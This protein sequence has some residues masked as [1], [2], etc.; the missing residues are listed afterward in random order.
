VPQCSLCQHDHPDDA[1]F[2]SRCGGFLRTAHGGP[3]AGE[4]RYLTLIF[5][6]LVD[7]TSLA[8]A[9]GPENYS[10][11]LDVFHERSAEVMTRFGGFIPEYL[12]DG[13]LV[14][15]GYP[16]AQEDDAARAAQATLE[17]QSAIVSSG[18]QIRA[19]V[20]AFTGRL[21]SRAAIHTGFV[22][23]R[24]VIRGGQHRASPPASRRPE[25]AARHRRDASA[26]AWAVG[27]RAERCRADAR[28]STACGDLP[29]TGPP[30][31]R[32]HRRLA[33]CA[34]TVRRPRGGD[35]DGHRMLDGRP[36]WSRPDDHAR[37]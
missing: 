31:C 25:F 9:L 33:S 22:I 16:L 24:A 11:V 15:F 4:R 6:D 32:D 8:E 26:L 37:R 20:P 35:C 5:C 19:R 30:P 29:G 18:P 14:L 2:C 34:N 7:S 12:G 10:Y 28:H 36:S 27:T 17:L 21:R 1:N 13:V 23:T 3:D